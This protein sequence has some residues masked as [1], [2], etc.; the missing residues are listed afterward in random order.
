MQ[1]G[2]ARP[3][4]D[5]T[6]S[7]R[8]RTPPF[9][10]RLSPDERAILERNAAGVPLGTYIRNRLFEGTSLSSPGRRRSLVHDHKIIAKLLAELGRSHLA[11]NVNQLAKAAN[12]GILP[13]GPETEAAIARACS[14]IELMRNMLLKALGLPDAGLR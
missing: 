9:S 1:I 6:Y 7:K 14:S 8:H 11:S 4:A 10:L 3:I 12:L 5:M 2:G 13:L